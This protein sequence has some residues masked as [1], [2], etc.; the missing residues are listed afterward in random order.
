MGDETVDRLTRFR[1]EK[2]DRRWRWEL[3]DAAIADMVRG[4][5]K[6][7]QE[8]LVAA[9]QRVFDE[10]RER[11]LKMLLDLESLGRLISEELEE[12]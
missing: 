4:M 8:A 7:A 9:R 12:Q 11:V 5:P 1:L 6:E 2:N 3:D 10:E